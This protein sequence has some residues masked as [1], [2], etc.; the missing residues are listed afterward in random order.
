[1]ADLSPFAPFDEQN[2]FTLQATK[3][4]QDKEQQAN[5]GLI[6]RVLADRAAAAQITNTNEQGAN[7]MAN[8]LAAHG[9]VSPRAGSA[10]GIAADP[11]ATDRAVAMRRA[12]DAELLGRAAHN[13]AGGGVFLDL[14]KT[15]NMEG[16]ADSPVLPGLPS[17]ALAS[18]LGKPVGADTNKEKIEST[19][20]TI[21]GKPVRVSRE[22]DTKRNV[23][24]TESPES[25]TLAQ[26][27]KFHLNQRAGKPESAPVPGAQVA[28]SPATPPPP[29]PTTLDEATRRAAVVKIISDVVKE[30]KMNALPAGTEIAV[31]ANGVVYAIIGGK[32]TRIGVHTEAKGI[33]KPG[34]LHI[35]GTK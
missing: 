6:Q 10:V 3:A 14:S 19:T 18:M 7:T 21:D 31:D 9:I 32:P 24:G 2:R 30:P 11:N 34:E 27:L 5:L 26:V 25:N 12:T 35:I 16:T 13:F 33:A 23:Y 1:M 8:T 17:G 20:Y 4:A 22:G 28:A 29:L 15:K